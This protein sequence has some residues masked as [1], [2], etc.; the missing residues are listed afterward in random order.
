MS[1]ETVTADATDGESSTSDL[2]DAIGGKRILLYAVLALIAVYFLV[3][4]EAGLVTSF[5]TNEAVINTAPYLPPGP[6]G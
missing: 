4:L 5:K 6:D 3:P 1:Q 2:R